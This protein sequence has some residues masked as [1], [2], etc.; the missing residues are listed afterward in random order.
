MTDLE[1]ILRPLT[2]AIARIPEPLLA[3]RTQ[4][5]AMEAAESARHGERVRVAQAQTEAARAQAAAVRAAL[6]ALGRRDDEEDTEQDPRVHE[7]VVGLRVRAIEK[8]S[9]LLDIPAKGLSLV[10]WAAQNPAKAIVGLAGIASILRILSGL[11]PGLTPIAEGLD[12]GMRA[13]SPTAQ[14]VP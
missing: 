2:R 3:I 4:L 10:T 9:G 5:V 11:V 8:A 13:V 14:E 1:P 7:A 6:K 12:A